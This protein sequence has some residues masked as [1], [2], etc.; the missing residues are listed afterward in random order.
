MKCA[1]KGITLHVAQ[2]PCFSISYLHRSNITPIKLL[3]QEEL[4]M[5]VMERKRIETI[6]SRTISIKTLQVRHV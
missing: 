2:E 6:F 4:L 1:R 3:G 5:S